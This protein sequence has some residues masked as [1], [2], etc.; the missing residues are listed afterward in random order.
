MGRTISSSG[1]TVRLTVVA[2]SHKVVAAAGL[3]DEDGVGRLGLAAA[4]FPAFDDAGRKGAACADIRG[5]VAGNDRPWST[6]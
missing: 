6:V 5:A 2:A 1:V 3:G 4:A